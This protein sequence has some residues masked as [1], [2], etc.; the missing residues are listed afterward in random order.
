MSLTNP[1]L[2]AI[3]N[4]AAQVSAIYASL[5]NPGLQAI[6]NLIL[7]VGV[8]PMESNQPRPASNPQLT[9]LQTHGDS[10]V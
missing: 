1:G 7:V 8:P 5:T 4:S 10:R 2:Q 3:R 6:R 9:S